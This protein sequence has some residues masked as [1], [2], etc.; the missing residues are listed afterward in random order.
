MRKNITNIL[1]EKFHKD[2]IE[3]NVSKD[4][5]VLLSDKKIFKNFSLKNTKVFLDIAINNY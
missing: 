2:L 1:L 5:F 3:K 4:K